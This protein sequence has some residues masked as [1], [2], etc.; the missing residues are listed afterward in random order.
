MKPI[1]EHKGKG[2][3]VLWPSG[4]PGRIRELKEKSIIFRGE[5]IL[6]KKRKKNKE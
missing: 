1:I 2:C 6:L 5:T 3:F 4:K